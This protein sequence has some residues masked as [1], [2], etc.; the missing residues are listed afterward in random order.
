MES[1]QKSL[2]LI[3]KFFEFNPKTIDLHFTEILEKS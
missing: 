2:F 1:R 3:L